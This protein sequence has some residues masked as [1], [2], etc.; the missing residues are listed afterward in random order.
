MIHLTLLAALTMSGAATQESELHV[1]VSN[2]VA[3]SSKIRL[4]INTRNL[5]SVH[6]QCSPVD[7]LKW[8]TFPE[9]KEKPKPRPTSPPIRKFDFKIASPEQALNPT[10]DYFS[11]QVNLPPMP[12]GFYLLEFSAGQKTDWTVVNITNLCVDIHRSPTKTLGWVTNFK[13]GIPVSGAKVG[14]YTMSGVFQQVGETQRDGTVLFQTPPGTS[15]LV[16]RTRDDIAAIA[17]SGINPN[18]RLKCLFQTD[19]PIYRPGQTISYKA[20]LRLTHDQDYDRV[21]QSSVKVQLRDPRDNPL[22]E[23]TLTS[24]NMGSVAGSFKIPQEGMLGAY[25]L[26]LTDSKSKQSAYQTFTVAAYRKPEYKVDVKAVKKRYLA[27]DDI[28]FIVDTSYY[29]GAPVPQA[30][31]R[32]VIRR[33]DSP[34]SSIQDED[35]WFYGGDGNLYPRDTFRNSAA[36]ADGEAITDI[37]GKADILF[38]TDPEAGDSAYSISLTVTDS[39]RRQVSASSGVPVYAS[40]L[41]ISLEA[42][43]QTVAI[44][45]L[46]PLRIKLADLD[47]KAS[48]GKVSLQE[49]TGVWSDSEGRWKPKILTTK[50]VN[51]PIS[52]SSIVALPAL[53]I[54]TVEFSA[55]IKDST[56][57]K[58][59]ALASAYVAGLRLDPVQQK[60]PSPQLDLRLNKH[61]F[62]PGDTVRT[63]STTNNP[64]M[65]VLCILSGGDLWNYKVVYAKDGIAMWAPQV[66]VHQSPNAYIE[67]EQWVHGQMLHRTALVPVPD[68]SRLLN[69][70]VQPD[71]AEYKPGDKATYRIR[72][73]NDHGKGISAEV[74]LAVIDEA[75]YAIS[76]DITPDPYSYYWGIRENNVQMFQSA[77][78][79]LSGGAFQN[80]NSVAPVRQRFEDTAFWH[81]MVKTDAAGQASVSFEMP[82]NLTSWRATARAITEDTRVGSTRT[83]VTATRPVT[84]RLATPRVISQGDVL[85]LVGTI[86]NRSGQAYDFDASLQAKDGFVSSP[87]T[88]R[89]RIAAHSEGVVKWILAAKTVPTSGS[90]TLTGRVLS[91]GASNPDLGDAL[92][93]AVPVVPRGL[94]E[95]TLLA[96]SVSHASTE[97]FSLP[98]N[99]LSKASYIEV[100]IAGGMQAASR[101][102]AQNLLNG[103]RYGTMWAVNGLKAAVALALDTK[104]DS[105]REAL[106]LLSK[107]QGPNGWG[108]WEDTPADAKITSEVGYSLALAEQAGIRIFPSLKSAAVNT[109]VHNY[110][111]SNL[112]EDKARLAASLLLLGSDRGKPFADEVRQRGIHLS[113]FATLRLSEGFALVDKE[114]AIELLKGQLHL[115]SNGPATAYIPVGFGIGWD[116]SET[117]TAAQ[118]LVTLQNL[119]A[120]SKLQTKIAK[121]LTGSDSHNYLSSEDGA[122]TSLALY[123]YGL[124]HQDA[125]SIGKAQVEINGK[126]FSLQHSTVGETASVEIREPVLQPSDNSVSISRTGDGEALYTVRVR[127]YRS[128]LAETVRGIRVNRRYEHRNEA[129]VWTEID[130]HVL[131]GEPVRCTVVIWGDDI[132]DALK[133]TEPLPAGFEFVDSEYTAQSRE[134]V[135]DGAILHYL[136]NHGSPTFFRYYLRAESDGQLIALPAV[137]E[138]LR[139]PASR[140]NSSSNEIKVSQ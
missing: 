59:Y 133:V 55:T 140:G 78:E 83:S 129:G 52:G 13:T 45:D 67:T 86:N 30:Q 54:G 90:M 132:P 106:A 57:R 128:T 92:Q 62:M 93:V 71:H 12:T 17:N 80:V 60:T 42:L 112:W 5:P 96:G 48:S 81:A 91:E 14:L 26:V 102:R 63:Y 95:S 7:A 8:V 31:V 4:N 116:A 49:T 110:L 84:F 85:T 97:K 44:G 126:S 121:R 21:S 27:G 25:T 56:G 50:V 36:A 18:G 127:Y 40:E 64:S 136:L 15:N 137:A 41:R 135:R 6:V 24:N 29:F 65:P 125:R 119:G 113:P 72:T 124:D 35:R 103:G 51:V 108:W 122:E 53:A 70:E 22:D 114:V 101:E 79:E 88:Q 131:P 16:V 23:V 105:V 87:E 134:E 73:T 117:Y 104:N 115:V 37:S 75:I 99:T 39:S 118:L 77:P 43:K 11:R 107:D 66:G 46:V 89:V 20:I 47:G 138:F 109:C 34:Y 94:T 3:P 130:G 100:V 123:R 120:D 9:G 69:V 1:W 82:G 111:V 76:Q 10:D 28:H 98:S 2:N 19:R 32:W 58:S 38:H 68:K 61:V 139:R 33:T 74:S